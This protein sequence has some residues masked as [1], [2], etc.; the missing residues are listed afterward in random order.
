MG[1]FGQRVASRLKKVNFPL[2]SALVR[3][4]AA[5]LWP[6]L[7]SPVQ[8]KY[9]YI[10]TTCAG[11]QKYCMYYTTP[12]TWGEAERGSWACPAWRKASPGETL[13]TFINTQ[14]DGMKMREP[15]S[16]LWDPAIGPETMGT[17]RNTGGCLGTSGNTFSLWGWYRL[18]RGVLKSGSLEIFKDQLNIVQE[19]C[20]SWPCSEQEL[21]F[22]GP[23]Q[24]QPFWNSVICKPVASLQSYASKLHEFG[25]FH[26]SWEWS[27]HSCSGIM[28]QMK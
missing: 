5:I 9:G 11:Q 4:H 19:T 16:S 24:P 15:D 28:E 6:G 21:D 14:Q 22:R 13:C 7:G 23:T 8:K 17:N 20:L 2:C 3:P 18:S 25:H 26:D 10:G 12:F 1:C 27:H